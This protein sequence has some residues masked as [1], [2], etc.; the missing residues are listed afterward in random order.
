[1]ALAPGEHPRLFLD[2]IALVDMAHDKRTYRFFQDTRHGRVL[3]A[4]S[5]SVDSSSLRSPIM[6]GAGWSSANG[7]SLQDWRPDGAP[8]P[9]QPRRSTGRSPG[10]SP[11]RARA[12]C[13]S[14]L[15]PRANRLRRP[16]SRTRGRRRGI[17]SAAR[18]RVE[19]VSDASGVDHASHSC[20]GLAA[21]GPGRR[22]CA[23]CGLTGSALR[24][25][26]KP[27]ADLICLPHRT[28]I[29]LIRSRAP[30]EGRRKIMSNAFF[31][32][33]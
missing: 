32:V 26:E 8:Q 28:T 3:I 19:P 25:S 15:P 16:I 9:Q 13:L 7:R 1:M 17:M 27:N 23:T 31:Y 33:F 2:M 6:S 20:S 10:R 4:E 24:H 22:A 11:D 14:L 5:Q 12:R 21:I 29:R 30:R 18:R